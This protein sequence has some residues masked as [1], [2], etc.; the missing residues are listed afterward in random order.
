MIAVHVPAPSLSRS[1]RSL[2]SAVRGLHIVDLRGDA[3]AA[4]IKA[5][6]GE[7]IRAGPSSELSHVRAGG[8][9]D[10]ELGIEGLGETVEHPKT[11][12][13]AASFK[14]CYG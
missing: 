10:G 5:F 4:K 7:P 8:D 12:Y 6:G 11:R 13:C 1:I 3:V 2:P 14:P 9:L